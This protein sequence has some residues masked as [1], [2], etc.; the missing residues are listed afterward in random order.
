MKTLVLRGL[1]NLLTACSVFL[2]SQSLHAANIIVGLYDCGVIL[3]N[4]SVN[5]G[6][7]VTWVKENA[8]DPGA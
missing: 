4:I 7:S 2:I 1:S 5:V 6:D 8:A 3:P